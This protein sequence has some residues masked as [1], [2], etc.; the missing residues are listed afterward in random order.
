MKALRIIIVIAVLCLGF[1]IGYRLLHSP[2]ASDDRIETAKVGDIR[3]MLR[4]STV[5]FHEEIPVKGSI[6]SRH[7]FAKETVT[8]SISFDLDSIE[9][10]E[11]KD[12]IVITL[13]REIIEIKESTE[14]GSYKVIDNWN[15]RLL[16]SDNFTT[17]EENAIKNKVRDNFRNTLYKRGMVRRARQEAAENLASMMKSL[18]GK[19]VVVTDNDSING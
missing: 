9:F 2:A 5:E 16:G 3:A 1:V 18:T 12:S 13:P 11:T 14:P 6:G 8:G 7:L 10:A 19:T 15:E 17:A 4:L